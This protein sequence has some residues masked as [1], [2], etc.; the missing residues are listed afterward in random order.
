MTARSA[1]NCYFPTDTGGPHADHQRFLSGAIIA[2]H[3]RMGIAGFGPRRDP[4]RAD[5]SER[6]TPTGWNGFNLRAMLSASACRCA[7]APT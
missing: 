2:G 3:S 5:Y 7:S 1:A 4:G 6:S